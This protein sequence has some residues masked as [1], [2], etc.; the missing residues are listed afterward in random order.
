MNDLAQIVEQAFWSMMDDV[1]TAFPGIIQSDYNYKTKT[2][3]VQPTIKVPIGDGMAALPKINRVQV[4]FPGTKRSVIQ[5][6]LKKGDGCLVICSTIAL[7]DWINSSGDLVFPGD[8][9]KFAATDAFCI[10][11]LFP[12][13]G[14]GKIGT[15]SGFE[16]LHESAKIQLTDD[17]KIKINGDSKQ[18]VTYAELASA[19]N[20]FLQ[21]L[22]SHTHSNGNNGSP[23]GAPIVSMSLDISES[24]TTSV[25]T[26]G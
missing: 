7:D 18:L 12:M 11:G 22:N 5:F 26:G 14:P 3:S 25:L 17:G 6:P 9:R 15:G 21:S 13:K 8:T 20:T 16:I 2:V 23:T 19:L 24:K 1:Y 10:P 4:I